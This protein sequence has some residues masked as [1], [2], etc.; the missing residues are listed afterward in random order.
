MSK[1]FISII[2]SL[3]ILTVGAFFFVLQWGSKLPSPEGLFG[4]SPIPPGG[5]AIE[6]PRIPR[7]QLTIQLSQRGNKLVVDWANL[8]A[9]TLALD[10]FRSLKNKNDWALWK[11][12]PLSTLDL[13]GGQASFNI[14]NDTFANYSFY[15]EARG[16]GGSGGGAGQSTSTI[17]WT[18]FVPQ[19]AT[20]TAPASPAGP[21]PTGP[22]PAGATP[23]AQSS[24]TPS[25][26]AAAPQSPASGTASAAT[27]SSSGTGGAGPASTGTPYYTPQLQISGYGPTP[28]GNFWVQ[29][30]D[31]RIQLSWQ[32]LPPQTTR[33]TIERSLAQTG[34]WTVVLSQQNP[35]ITGIHSVQIVDNTLGQPYY[36]EMLLYE[37]NVLIATYGPAYLPPVGG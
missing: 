10:I 13:P 22:G 11:T 5:P 20:T 30:V 12:I 3:F 18:T 2:L 9:N 14:G 7:V 4:G 29:H 28:A 24:S 34:P 6:V 8:P 17:L 1:Q 33:F 19:V 32:D 25:S 37:G 26:T 27:S 31:Q 23:G 36:Y 15:V 21:G 16:L 35:A